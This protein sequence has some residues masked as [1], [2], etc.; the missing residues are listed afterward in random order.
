[1]LIIDP[2]DGRLLPRTAAG[3]VRAGWT[4]GPIPGP[5]AH[6]RSGASPATHRSIRTATTTTS[7]VLQAPGNVVML[8]QGDTLAR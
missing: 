3:E 8:Q 7:W 2:L 4:P 6:W 1:M 5:T